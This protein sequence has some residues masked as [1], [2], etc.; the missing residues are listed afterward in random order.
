MG[1]KLEPV[2]VNLDYIHKHTNLKC[3]LHAP[4][5][6]DGQ[7]R[8]IRDY[9]KNRWPKFATN[10]RPILIGKVLLPVVFHQAKT[11]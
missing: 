8:K 2:L 6:S 7:S 1:I 10:L 5:L 4:Y 11:I 3:K 9:C